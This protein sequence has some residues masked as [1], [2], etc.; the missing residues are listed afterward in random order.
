MV[1]SRQNSAALFDGADNDKENVAENTF[2][3]HSVYTDS[4]NEENTD[5][6]QKEQKVAKS[7]RT[8]EETNKMDDTSSDDLFYKS[9]SKRRCNDEANHDNYKR[10]CKTKNGHIITA[11]KRNANENLSR[12]SAQHSDSGFSDTLQGSSE[13]ELFSSFAPKSLEENKVLGVTQQINSIL[14]ETS[15]DLDLQNSLHPSSHQAP[16]IN[17]D[18]TLDSR[19]E[20]EML[21]TITNYSSDFLPYGNILQTSPSENSDTTREPA[22]GSLRLSETW[23]NSIH[24][25]RWSSVRAEAA[26]KENHWPRDESYST[27]FLGENMELVLPD[28][29]QAAYVPISID[30]INPSIDFLPEKADFSLNVTSFPSIQANQNLE[31]PTYIVHDATA[32]LSLVLAQL[33]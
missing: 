21:E 26:T 22:E 27:E 3:A 16:H 12:D 32:D 13:D 18:F 6:F 11:Y 23:S 24:D 1:R 33:N 5:G 17:P 2:S 15:S 29:P 9:T 20:V 14:K 7:Q 10:I 8:F 28:I 31:Q 19:C 30:Q 4:E 25:T